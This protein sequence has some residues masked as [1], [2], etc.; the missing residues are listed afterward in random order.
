MSDTI[1]CVC[2]GGS[3]FLT[4]CGY[5]WGTVVVFSDALWVCMG[6]GGRPS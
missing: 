3:S 1:M 4:L 2:G 6:D 5:V